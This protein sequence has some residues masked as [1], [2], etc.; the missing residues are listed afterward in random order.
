MEIRRKDALDYH[1]QGRKGKI[2]ADAHQAL[3]HAM[4]FKSRLHAGR[5]RALQRDPQ[6]TGPFL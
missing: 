4:G 2:E 6:G 3:P 5:G 1:R